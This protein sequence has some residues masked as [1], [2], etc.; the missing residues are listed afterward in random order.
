MSSVLVVQHEDSCPV[1]R[2]GQWLAEA[3]VRVE[4]CRPYAGDAVPERVRQAGLVVLGGHM[5]A[6][7]DGVAPWLPASRALLARCV[8]ERV[9]VLGVCLG[10]QLLAVAC[11]GRVEVGPGGIEAGVVDVQWRPA[12]AGDA[13]FGGR[14]RTAGPSMHLDAVVELPPGAVWLGRTQAYPHQAFRVGEAAWGVQ[15]HPEVSV[16]TYAVWAANHADDW[17]RWGLSGAEVVAQLE[18]RDAEVAAAGRELAARF[19]A[20]LGVPGST[21]R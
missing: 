9:P 10:A 17:V 13:L 4:L 7:D 16:A 15:F 21:R 5:G 8:G 20:L 19:A 3:G 6:Y 11:G 2:L 14:T 18:R 12:A 1:D